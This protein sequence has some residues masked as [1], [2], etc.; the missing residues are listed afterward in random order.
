MHKKNTSLP[1]SNYGFAEQNDFYSLC[2]ETRD[3]RNFIKN[4]VTSSKEEIM[5]KDSNGNLV[6][7]NT[8]VNKITQKI[9]YTTETIINTIDTTINKSETKIINDNKTNT[10]LIIN[11]I[12]DLK[13]WWS[14][15]K[16]NW[17]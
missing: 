1:L 7:V 14:N 16:P 2:E 6:S 12:N 9:D 17:A 5:G 8:A 4:H 3:W 15:F 13:T 10:S 11:A